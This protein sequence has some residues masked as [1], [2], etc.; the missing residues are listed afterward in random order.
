MPDHLTK[1]ER[2]KLMSKVRTQ[3][4]SPEMQVRRF[5]HASG[6]RYRL[7]VKELDGRPDIVLPK[8]KSLVFVDG[9]FWHGHSCNKGKLP[10]SNTDF[11]KIKIDKNRLRDLRVRGELIEQGWNVLTIWECE[12]PSSLEKLANSIKFAERKF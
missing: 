2:S 4:T 7:N 5:L 12:I 10:K 6:F 9:C 8:Y 1:S 11:W 3:G